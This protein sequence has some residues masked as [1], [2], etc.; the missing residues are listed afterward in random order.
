MIGSKEMPADWISIKE[1]LTDFDVF[2]QQE[3]NRYVEYLTKGML[4]AIPDTIATLQS[5]SLPE[6]NAVITQWIPNAMALP[7]PE[8]RQ[9]MIGKQNKLQEMVGLFQ[10]VASY[11]HGSVANSQAYHVMKPLAQEQDQLLLRTI[12]M[13]HQRWEEKCAFDALKEQRMEWLG[14]AWQENDPQWDEVNRTFT[15]LAQADVRNVISEIAEKTPDVTLVELKQWYAGLKDF[16]PDQTFNI[17]LEANQKIQKDISAK[18]QADSLLAG[19][20]QIEHA[21]AFMDEM[22]FYVPQQTTTA[23][24]A[25]HMKCLAELNELIKQ[26]DTRQDQC[27]LWFGDAYAGW[28]TDWDRILLN[29]KRWR[30]CC[31]QYPEIQNHIELYRPIIAS[32][33]RGGYER[34]VNRAIQTAGTWQDSYAEIEAS[35]DQGTLTGLTQAE[36]E[37]RLAQ[38]ADH[39]EYLDQWHRYSLNKEKVAKEGLET[40]ALWPS[41]RKSIPACLDQSGFGKLSGCGAVQRAGKG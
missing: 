14:P 34:W 7:V 41:I 27:M 16:P 4:E 31:A 18:D 17:I 29:L 38:A 39:M 10:A 25:Q 37:E 19:L 30:L 1:K 9:C 21:I 33:D 15:I 6:V 12:D 24:I 35:F 11:L 40:H 32:S 3:E 28:N 23:Q 36:K 2:C 5:I 22:S 20:T 26:Q 13:L 8:V